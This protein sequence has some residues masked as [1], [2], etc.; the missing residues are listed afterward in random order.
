MTSEQTIALIDKIIWPILIFGIYLNNSKKIKLIIDVLISRVE[1]GA[2][3][4]FST[5]KI[6]QIPMS[7]PSPKENEKVT[8]NNIALLHSSWRYPRKDKDFKKKMYVIQVI[9]QAQNDVLDR[10]EYVKYTLHSSYPN[11][12]QIK[13]DRISKFQIKELAWGEFNLKATIKIKDQGDLIDL[14]RYIN[15]SETGEDLLIS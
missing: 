15:L 10:I 3:F 13:N 4:Q 12:V 1:K 9:V 14:V 11:R 2:E 7:L 8:E 5:I 6:G